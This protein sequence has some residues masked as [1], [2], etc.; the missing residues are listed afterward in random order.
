MYKVTIT[1]YFSGAHNLREYKGKCEN[2]HGHNWKVEVTV[3][4]KKLD[5]IGM[6]MDFKDLKKIVSNILSVLDHH[7]LNE[8][9]YFKQVNPTSENIAKFVYSRVQE[10]LTPKQLKVDTVRIWETAGSAAAYR[11][12]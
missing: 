3:T 9:S 5:N 7:Y 10:K 4:S 12:D 8:I 2:L 11:E 6:V 1:D